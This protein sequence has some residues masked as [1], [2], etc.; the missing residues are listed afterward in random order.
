M[1]RQKWTIE[2]KVGIV[3]GGARGIGFAISKKLLE[4]GAKV[5]IFDIREEG[6]R[7]AV[8]ELRAFHESLTGIPGDVSIRHEVQELIKRVLEAFG[9]IHFLVNNAGIS[10]KKEG[11]KV[12]MID[13]DPQEWEKVLGINLTGAFNCCQAVLPYL[14]RQKAGKIVNIASIDAR[15][16][17]FDVGVHYA[18]SK[19]GLVALT[20]NLAREVASYNINVNAIAPGC[21]NTEIFRNR[22]QSTIE[23]YK[24]QIPLGRIGEPEDVAEATFSYCQMLPII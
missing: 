7:S 22:L 2:G 21:I 11:K 24:S 15:T 3:T 17:G 18:A 19:A 12:P 8:Q 14:V 9:G 10:P 6:V 5:A 16:G 13:M 20:K 1:V 4:E 23:Y